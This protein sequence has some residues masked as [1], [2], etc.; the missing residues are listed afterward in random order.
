MMPSPAFAPYLV[1]R[2]I[3]AVVIGASAGG[4]DAML[5]LFSGLPATY[6]LPLIALLHM[7]EMRES[8]LATVFQHRMSMRVKEAEDKETIVPGKLYFASAGYHLSIEHSLSFS[9]SCEPPLHFSRPSIDILMESAAD[10]YG[11][12]LMGI[13]L[14]GAS[15][16]G[17]MGMQKIK[18]SG[19]LTVIQDPAEAEVAY[20]PQEAIKLQTPDLILNLADIHRLLM[21]LDHQHVD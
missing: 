4:V 20:M 5:R 13:L 14:T 2:N 7:Q 15:H 3:H 19:G 12:T 6:P 16:D 1:D 8:R 17:A 11:P 10:A 21:I 18:E 9:I